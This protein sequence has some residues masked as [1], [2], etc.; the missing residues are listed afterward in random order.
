MRLDRARPIPAV[1]AAAY[2]RERTIRRGLAKTLTQVS[3]Y[4]VRPG[5]TVVASGDQGI[6]YG[7]ASLVEFNL[8]ED[9][10]RVRT[11]ELTAAS[12]YS[13]GVQPPGHRWQDVPA[14]TDWTEYE[15]PEV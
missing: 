12:A 3:N 13:W 7:L 14:G 6:F 9:Q 2:L 8:T 11:R 1:G 15:P 10:M 4:T 5:H